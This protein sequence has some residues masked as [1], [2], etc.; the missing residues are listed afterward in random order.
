MALKSK[1]MPL[2]FSTVIKY[3]FATPLSPYCCFKFIPAQRFSPFK[4]SIIQ[5]IQRL[6]TIGLKYFLLGFLF[7]IKNTMVLI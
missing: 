5:P 3:C 4:D 6:I 2:P 7:F 1:V